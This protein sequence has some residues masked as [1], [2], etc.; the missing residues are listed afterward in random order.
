[1]Q[2]Y[3]DV[4]SYLRGLRTDPRLAVISRQMAADALGLQRTTIDKRLKNKKLDGIKIGKAICVTAWSL[5]EE[6]HHDDVLIAK[7][8]HRLARLATLG[9][10]I[11]YS[12]FMA[13][14]NLD[15]NL[16]A[17]RNRVGRLLGRVSNKTYKAHGFLLSVLVVYKGYG[18]P[19]GSFFGLAESLEDPDYENAKTDTD[20]FNLHL[21]KVIDHFAKF[22]Q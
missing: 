16:T 2:T 4:E 10:T 15:S 20:Y 11:E 22:P 6:L 17:D 7:M 9:Q 5:N 13:E 19:A 3:P 21:Q 1:M 12:P 8:E 14:F 18:I